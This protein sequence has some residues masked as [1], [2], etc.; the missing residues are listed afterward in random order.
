MKKWY[1]LGIVFLF[2]M[3]CFSQVTLH[4]GGSKPIEY[5]TL[6]SGAVR[7]FYEMKSVKDPA[8]PDKLTEDYMAL[9]IGENGVSR[10][11]SDNKRRQDSLLIEAFKTSSNHANLGKLFKD[12]GIP[13]G[14]DQREIFKN[15]PEG[16]ITV[17]DHIVSAS[18]LYEEDLNEIQWQILP[19]TKTILSY[20]CQ[21]AVTDFRG[22]HYEAWFTPDLPINDGPWKFRGLPG[23]IL[24]IEDSNKHF[25]FIAVALENISTPVTFPKKDYIKTSRK[26]VAKIQKR[27]IQD[28]MGFINDSNPGMNVTVKVQNEDGSVSSGNEIKIPYNPIELD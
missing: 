14:G 3:S 8:K 28:P 20:S 24:S 19:D 2:S 6:D 13:S 12:A 26:E 21:K 15:Y 10:F 11:Y 22:R 1:L 16:K 17:T 4:L 18:Y 5:E 23:L 25:S 9:E 27:F 7:L